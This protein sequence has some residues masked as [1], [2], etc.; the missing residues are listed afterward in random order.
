M[1]EKL[2]LGSKG[3]VGRAL[4]QT[5]L[6]GSMLLNVVEA[7]PQ[8]PTQPV[9]QKAEKLALFNELKLKIQ[10]TLPLIESALP[11]LKQ[12]QQDV[13][14]EIVNFISTNLDAIDLA[15][16]DLPKNYGAY[17]SMQPNYSAPSFK[18]FLNK[19]FNSKDVLDVSILVHELSYIVKLLRDHTM[20]SEDDWEKY[21][22][23]PGNAVEIRTELYAW[24]LQ[25]DFLNALTDNALEK[26]A[27]RMLL[28][29]VPDEI[30]AIHKKE[31]EQIL[32]KY[33]VQSD[34]KV[35]QRLLELQ[36]VRL[37]H[38]YCSNFGFSNLYAAQV[39]TWYMSNGIDMYELIVP[40]EYQAQYSEKDD[41]C[42]YSLP[43]T[44][45]GFKAAYLYTKLPEGYYFKRADL[46]VRFNR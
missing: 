9:V 45:S 12:N 6:I 27:K 21:Y 15:Q 20:L 16:D 5:A 40:E 43:E 17:V 10:A 44:M 23:A 13:I 7:Y 19:K 28:A 3:L 36:F 31:V 2:N 37:N 34:K 11:H 32:E 26:A 33:N 8:A 18:L 42:V 46:I 38:S 35:L 4:I 1:I 22:A 24:D 25:I 14:Y 41:L 39:A 30:A 29:Q